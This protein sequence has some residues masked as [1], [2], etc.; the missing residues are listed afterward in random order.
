MAGRFAKWGVK[1][2]KR[3]GKGW[4]WARPA[5]W[6]TRKGK[7]VARKSRAMAVRDRF[8]ARGQHAVVRVP[9][10]LKKQKRDKLIEIIT[11]EVGVKEDPA[12]SNSGPRVRVYQAST[13]L[14]GS[15]WPWCQAFVCW[16]A[17]QAGFTMPYRGAYVPHFEAWAREAGRFERKPGR[18]MAVICDF[19]GD[20]T[21]DHVEIVVSVRDS[22]VEC[23]GGNTSPT[24]GGSQSNGGMVCHTFRPWAV[25]KGFVRLK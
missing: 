4:R 17:Q 5:G 8:I 12:G 18:G 16:A 21:A 7:K 2:R 13:Q 23:I 9:D 11:R 20:G 14:E 24:S 3:N 22:G 6:R 19:N 1:V 15:G 25:C 10:A